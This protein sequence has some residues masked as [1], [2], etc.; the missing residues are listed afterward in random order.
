MKRLVSLF[1]AAF[2]LMALPAHAQE[3]PSKPIHVLTTSSAGG[4]SDT[5]MRVLGD[6]LH[7]GTSKNSMPLGPVRVCC[8]DGMILGD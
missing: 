1:L 2:A 8:P 6:E 7:K 3:F 5:F 4:L